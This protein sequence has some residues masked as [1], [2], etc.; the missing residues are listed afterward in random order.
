MKIILLKYA[1]L[2]FVGQRGRCTEHHDISLKVLSVIFIT[3]VVC[4]FADKKKIIT[5]NG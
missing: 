5:S 1:Y 2:I 4:I 3:S